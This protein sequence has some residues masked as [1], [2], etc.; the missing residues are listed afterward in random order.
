[1]QHLLLPPAPARRFRSPPDAPAVAAPTF[2]RLTGG[3]T[4][5]AR[6]SGARGAPVHDPWSRD[7]V[8]ARHPGLA[9]FRGAR[10]SGRATPWVARPSGCR[11]PQVARPLGLRDSCNPL[12]G[13]SRG[14]SKGNPP[15]V[16]SA[17]VHGLLLST[18]RACVVLGSR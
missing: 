18:H 15:V 1:M 11:D 2:A 7:P 6:P 9:A 10:P 3:R 12:G 4:T 8:V 13:R 16:Q 14:P 17:A 5:G